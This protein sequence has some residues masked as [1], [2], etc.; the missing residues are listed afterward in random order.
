MVHFLHE[1][2]VQTSQT[3]P[4]TINVNP[5]EQVTIKAEGNGVI[6]ITFARTVPQPLSQFATSNNQVKIP[7]TGEVKLTLYGVSSITF[8]GA[9]NVKIEQKALGVIEVPSKIEVKL[10][11][12]EN[13]VTVQVS[14]GTITNVVS[15]G[16]QVPASQIIHVGFDPITFVGSGVSFTVQDYDPITGQP[17]GSP[18]SVNLTG[19]S[20]YEAEYPA[21]S[22]IIRS[23]TG[24][25]Y[26]SNLQGSGYFYIFR[27]KE[28]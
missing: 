24:F 2:N 4:Q 27:M 16:S 22:T 10:P 15:N 11:Q 5:T 9:M 20:Q 7:V 3:T 13:V 1:V 18:I 26:I 12:I 21:G 19:T 14:N 8:S 28:D 6:V 25:I 23:R 17:A